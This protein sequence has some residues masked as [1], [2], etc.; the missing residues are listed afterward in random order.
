MIEAKY[1]YAVPRYPIYRLYSLLVVWTCF[2]FATLRC[3]SGFDILAVVVVV[4]VI[5]VVVLFF[6]VRS[7]F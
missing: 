5:V 1:V 7:I 2:L 6:Y 3:T 4:V